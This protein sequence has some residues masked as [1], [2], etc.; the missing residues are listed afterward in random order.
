M[1]ASWSAMT[2]CGPLLYFFCFPYHCAVFLHLSPVH[3]GVQEVRASL[4]IF[5]HM[6][7]NIT[8]EHKEHWWQKIW[9]W[10]KRDAIRKTA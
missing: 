6:G 5:Q 8:W 4:T 3:G 2:V 7:F 1:L 9:L 10:Q